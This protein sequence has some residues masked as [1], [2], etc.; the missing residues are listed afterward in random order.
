MRRT[1]RAGAGGLCAVVVGCALLLAVA[2]V[3]FV[4]STTSTGGSFPSQDAR[5]QM[6]KA[7]VGLVGLW[8]LTRLDYRFFERN[9]YVIYFGVIGLLTVMLAIKLGTG[10]RNRFINLGF[11]QIQPSEFMKFGLI[12][13]LAKYLRY[14]ED[15]RTPGGLV[16]PLLLALVPMALVLLQPNLGLSLMFPP[17]LVAMLFAA[18]A[19]PRH[20][21]LSTTF[22]ILILPAAYFVGDRVP[23]L[24]EYQKTRIRSFFVRDDSTSKNQGYQLQQSIIAVG[25]GGPLGVGYHE[26]NQNVLEHLPEKET[27]FIFSIVA[28]ETGF[29]GAAGV[30]AV[31]WVF[32][33]SIL[34]VSYRTREPFGRLLTAGIAVAFAAQSFENIGMT[35]GITPIT[36][37]A[38]PFLSLAG[39]TLVSSFAMVGIVISVARHPVRVVAS[40]DLD[41]RE[42]RRLV[43]L[44]EERPGGLLQSRWPI[45]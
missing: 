45:D 37:V 31:Y 40:R 3:L 20:L 6:I 43:P 11:F 14:R 39:S 28:E 42:R 35:V 17:I 32:V 21:I 44:I 5:G 18:G 22:G 26:G 25:S 9:A 12:A 41:P 19:K 23:L 7:A 27:D 33:L 15:Q 38:L 13:A 30:V 1:E 24:M 29:A 10:G 8:I 36:G 2:G 16:G 34:G 4:H